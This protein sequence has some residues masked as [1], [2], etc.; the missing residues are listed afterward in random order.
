MDSDEIRR[1]LERLK[2]AKPAVRKKAVGAK[3]PAGV[4]RKVAR[5][6]GTK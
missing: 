5:G 6:A 1:R 3:E 2:P 4:A